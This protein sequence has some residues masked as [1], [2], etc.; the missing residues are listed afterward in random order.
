[1][2]FMRPFRLILALAL[3]AVSVRAAAPVSLTVP[4]FSF[5]PSAGPAVH[6]SAVAG[7][8]PAP[9]SAPESRI[10][11][12]LPAPAQASPLMIQPAAVAAA[13][14]AI[15]Q[16]LAS[17]PA[18]DA[19]DP[20]EAAGRYAD[21]FDGSAPAP[22][23]EPVHARPA[24]APG[25]TFRQPLQL[26]IVESAVA[27]ALPALRDSVALGGWNG[28]HTTL[29]ESCC[30]DAAPKLA[31]LLRAQGIPARLV[32][33]EFHYYVLLD[34]PDG[35]IV[36]DPTVRQ[37]FGKKRAPRSIPHVFVGDLDDLAAFYRRHAAS[38]TTIFDPARIYFRDAAVR[39][40]AL[41]SL[42]AAVRAGGAADHEPLRRFLGLPPVAPRPPDA[43]RRINP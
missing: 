16:S 8:A 7:L 9:L 37:F 38:K 13:R 12:L 40:D 25:P 20:D 5:A 32:E 2:R 21:F 15:L 34:L 6:P 24:V 14:P 39:E 10:P 19:S 30:G 43:P 26:N 4:R 31:L 41:R 33:A 3:A 27:R 28:P 42:E 11:S 17:V 1:M 22:D 23:G 18:A 36:V 35:Q 29:D